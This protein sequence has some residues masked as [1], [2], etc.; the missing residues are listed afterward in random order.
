MSLI[1][2]SGGAQARGPGGEAGGAARGRDPAAALQPQPGAASSPSRARRAR[3]LADSWGRRGGGE[4]RA[5]PDALSLL[6]GRS[7]LCAQVEGFRYRAEDSLKRVSKLAVRRARIRE[8]EGELLNA[9]TLEDHFSANPQATPFPTSLRTRRRP[10]SPDA[11]A[12]ARSPAADARV[13]ACQAAA[14]AS[15][16]TCP[17]PLRTRFTRFALRRT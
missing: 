7:D 4:R 16:F 12:A 13:P 5:P 2:W 11:A 15:H 10:A 6:R 17:R 1:S 8:I 9:S 14:R 3:G